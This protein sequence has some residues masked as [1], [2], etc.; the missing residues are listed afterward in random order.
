MKILAVIPA[1]GGSKRLHRKNIYPLLG[2]P[3]ISYAIEAC[4]GSRY[5]DK[6]NVYVSTEDKEI[7]SVAL[8]YGAKVIN[9]P[10]ELAEDHVWTQDV[11]SHALE[12]SEIEAGN[13]FDVLVRVQANSPQVTSEKIDECIKK[14]QDHNLWEV[15]T[16][17][18]DGIEDAAVH[19]MI[20]RCVNQRALSVYKGVVRTEYIDV[21]DVKD[22]ER[23]STIM[24]EK[25]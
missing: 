6:K 9:R 10:E 8:Q 13:E 2:R 18:E 14:L 22:I 16:V 7:A 21:H 15:F 20:R 11:L 4:K 1:R 5:L 3:L 19:V 23:I 12:Y 17:D 25:K 24:K